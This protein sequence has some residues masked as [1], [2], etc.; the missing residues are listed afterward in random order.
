MYVHTPTC[1]HTLR[2]G[3]FWQFPISIIDRFQKKLSSTLGA[4]AG[5]EYQGMAVMEIMQIS[6]DCYENEC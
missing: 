5:H 2:D 6:E 3:H 1:T 4:C